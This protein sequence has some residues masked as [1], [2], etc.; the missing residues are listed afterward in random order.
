MSLDGKQ[1]MLASL[2]TQL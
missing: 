1:P 2:N